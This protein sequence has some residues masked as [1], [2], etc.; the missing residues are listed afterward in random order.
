MKKIILA[1]NSPQRKKLLKLLGIKF[2]I[3]P[4]QA[5][6]IK[7]IQTTCAALVKKNA[8][9]KAEDIASRVKEG[10]VIGADTVVYVGNNKLILK[11]RNLKEAKRNLKT[12]FSRPQ[13]V[14]TGVAVIDAKTGKQIV[15]YEK[16]RVCMTPLTDKEIDGYHKKV[17]PFGKAGGFDIEGV[18]SVFIHRVEGCYTNVIGLPMA[19]L[20]RILKKFGVSALSLLMMFFLI[21]CVTEYNLATGKEET[22]MYTTEKEVKIG[23]KVA[24]QI[25]KQYDVITDVDV[26]ER[27]E[28]ILDK[29]VAVS[30]RRDLVYFIKVL[31]DDEL[32]NAASIPGGYVYLFSGLMEK[33]ENDDQLAG[34][35]AHEVGHITAKH[36]LKRLQASYGALLIQVLAVEA[37]GGR[38]ASGVNLALTSLFT[39]HSQKAEFE[40]DRLGVKYMQK[41]GYDPKEMIKFLEIIKKENAKEPIRR[42]SY[43]KTHPHVTKRIAVVN[44]E[45][46]G[47]MKYRDYLILIGEYE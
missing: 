32:L 29:I 9:L 10:I 15:D 8:L 33:I 36:G 46:T 19:K 38:V 17:S 30:D 28:R 18:G 35:I 13:W 41:A 39:E 44:Q 16:T 47:Q 26:N 20:F 37:G 2:S 14:Y 7:K 25:E 6:E 1:S 21:G 27:V 43:W 22:L 3:C 24:A 12:L 11:P 23:E 40:S 4:S 31:D 45:I 5:K 42:F 34:V